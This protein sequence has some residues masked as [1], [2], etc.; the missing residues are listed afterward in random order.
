MAPHLM[1]TSSKFVIALD[2]IEDFLEGEGY[3]FLRL[4]ILIV[5]CATAPLITA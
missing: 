4:V 3:K 2:V 1:C 5:F